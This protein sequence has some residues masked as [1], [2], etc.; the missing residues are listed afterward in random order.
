MDN[1]QKTQTHIPS[2]LGVMLFALGG[3][4][5]LG[6]GLLMAVTAL[7]SLLTS[8]PV[9]AQQ[10]VLFMAFSF[11]GILL[12]AAAFF[13]LQKVLQKPTADAPLS[14]ALPRWM[15]V[16]A[17]LMSV[18]SIMIGSQI[19][20]VE[21]ANW[22]I[23]PFLTIPAVALPLGVLLAF[24]AWKLPLGTRWQTWSVL[25]LSMTLTP[26]L[27]LAMEAVL[28]IILLIGVIAYVAMQ[29]ELANEIQALSQ[30]IMILGPQSEAAQELLSPFLTRPGVMVIALIYMAVLVPAIEELLKPLGVW[31]LAGKLESSAQGFTLGALSGAGYGLIETVGASG[32][33]SEWASLLSS[34]IGTGLLHI[35]T[36]GLMGAAIVL[37]WR[38]RRY[39][40]L[41]GTYFLAILLHGLWNAFAILFTF[42]NLAELL[43]Q[44]GQLATI[45]PAIIVI[46]SLLAAALFVILIL[47]NRRLRERI[48][49]A[50]QSSIFPADPLDQT[51]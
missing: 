28:A 15:I 7:V 51:P 27:L 1:S 9:P 45:Q 19:L 47:S 37:A 18:G 30:R 39:L 12:F 24:G 38:E 31:L 35:T 5:L 2:L 13:C 23:L 34:R 46:M 44:P 42:S 21:P 41:L 6:M 20:T 26:I 43:K 40:R 33:V 48:L 29:P 3:V 16:V 4:F 14:I 32:Q 8:K 10:T 22:L 11:E 50:R 25:G 17:V 49:P 36:S